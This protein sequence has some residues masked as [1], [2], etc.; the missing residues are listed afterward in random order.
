MSFK[1]N[2]RKEEGFTLIEVVIAIAILAI[3]LASVINY[4]INSTAITSAS[5]DRRE[6]LQLARSVIED[7]KSSIYNDSYGD[8][9][10][11]RLNS[12]ES[13]FNNGDWKNE[14]DFFDFKDDYGCKVVVNNYESY[15]DL[16]E[17]TV[18]VEWDDENSIEL[19][20]LITKR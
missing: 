20:T 5:K 7:M 6:A 14:E 9:F 10:T 11:E 4:F 1:V 3:I 16:K 19:K 15:S 17:I 12:R 18:R 8:N 13:D 2:T